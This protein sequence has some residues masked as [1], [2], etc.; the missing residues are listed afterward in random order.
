MIKMARRLA[1]NALRRF[2]TVLW[3]KYYRHRTA[4]LIRHHL[5]SE[6]LVFAGNGELRLGNDTHVMNALFNLSSG[7]IIIGDNVAF[8]HNVSCITG[9]HD[10]TLTNEKRQWDFPTSGRNIVIENGVWVGSNVT[11]LAP[12]IIGKNAVI[13]AHSLVNRDVPAD[14]VYGGVPA[15]LIKHITYKSAD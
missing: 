12:C 10:Y 1:G 3:N 13:A 8:G 15:K 5:I 14:T 6:K 9:T 2:A 11:I 7:S 4:D